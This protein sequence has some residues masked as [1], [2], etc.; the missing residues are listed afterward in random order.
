MRVL[1]LTF[2]EAVEICK[3]LSSEQRMQI[4]EFISAGP[5]NVNDISERMG[6]PFSTTVFN[7]KKLE[8]AGLISPTIVPGRGSQKISSIKYNQII[9]NL[10]KPELNNQDTLIYEMPI[11]EF[12]D[13]KVEP[14]CGLVNENGHLGTQNDPRSFYEP[15]RREAQHLF[16]SGNGFVE[17]RYPNRLPKGSIPEELEFSAELCSEAPHYQLDW[18]SDITLWINHVEIGTWTSQ[19]DFGGKRGFLTPEW[20]PINSSQYGL[21]KY[22]SI[23]DQGTFID[24]VR[25]SDVTIDQLNLLQIPFIS[26]KIGI[27]DDAV[28][29]GGLNLFG[30]KFGNYDQDLILKVLYS[31][32]SK[33]VV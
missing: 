3:A 19:G 13:C 4:M 17:Y 20:V 5:L 23:N 24:G 10:F 22:W 32:E 12:V 27:K 25:I 33:S 9:I 6:I 28:H 15:N 7:V 18:P 21:L 30:K 2:K 16:L 1:E 31:N 26:V 29:S 11:G 14:S 8:E